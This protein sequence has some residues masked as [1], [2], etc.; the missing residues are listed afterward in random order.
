MGRQR[1]ALRGWGGLEKSRSYLRLFHEALSSAIVSV[2]M[3][4]C[5][6]VSS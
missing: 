6:H 5:I 4:G 2:R 3:L 1:K